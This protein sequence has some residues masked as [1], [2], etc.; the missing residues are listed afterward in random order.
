[1]P[2]LS[3]SVFVVHDR[4]CARAR[5]RRR[6]SRQSKVNKDLADHDRVDDE[7]DDS[8]CAIAFRTM[9]NVFKKD[10][11]N[12]SLSMAGHMTSDEVTGDTQL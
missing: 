9:Q 11:L 3:D 12:Q 6:F 5:A 7:A 8:A 2:D 10:P 1:M 4:R